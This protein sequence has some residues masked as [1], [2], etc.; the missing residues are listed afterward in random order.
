MLKVRGTEIS[1]NRGDDVSLTLTIY[2]VDGAPYE[3]QE[4]DKLYFSAKAKIDDP[5][6]A[7]PPKEL[8]GNVIHIVPADTYDLAFGKYVYDV[9]FVTAG[10][11]KSTIIEPS[12]LEIKGSVTAFG[13]R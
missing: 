1:F 3:L 5:N 4:G 7:I 10:G 8:E 12:T 11:R 2:D 6:Y 9:Q 13:D